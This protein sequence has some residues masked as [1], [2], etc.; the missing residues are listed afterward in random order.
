MEVW[1]KE[2]Q[3]ILEKMESKNFPKSVKMT[4]MWGIRLAQD[5]VA[6]RAEVDKL[7][8][9]EVTAKQMVKAMQPMLR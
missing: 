5:P 9:G 2:E 7:L 6:A 4:V 3:E 8:S 1:D